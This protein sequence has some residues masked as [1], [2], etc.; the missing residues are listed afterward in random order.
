MRQI[1]EIIMNVVLSS[2]DE[3]E[4]IRGLINHTSIWLHKSI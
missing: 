3:V 4:N 1:A 2:S